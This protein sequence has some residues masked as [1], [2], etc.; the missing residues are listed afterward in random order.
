MFHPDIDEE[1]SEKEESEVEEETPQ[2]KPLPTLRPADLLLM[3]ERKLSQLKHEIGLLA[4]AVVENPEEN[5]SC[6][7]SL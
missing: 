5:V 6:R 2:R 4:S 7:N 1:E 3:R